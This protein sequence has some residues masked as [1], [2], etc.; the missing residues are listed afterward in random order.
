MDID[1]IIYAVIA[2]LLLG[3]LWVVFGRRNDSDKQRRN[4]FVTWALRADDPTAGQPVREPSPLL[5]AF[6]SAPA[7]MAGGLEQIKSRD[8]RFDEKQFL[9]DA[10]QNFKTIVEDFAKG[11]IAQMTF[12]LMP[13]VLAHFQNALEVRHAA[14][15]TVETRVASITDA[16]TTSVR[17]EGDQAFI[18]VRFISHQENILR[19]SAGQVIAGEAGKIEEVT[20]VWT[21]TRDMV[22]SDS[23]WLVSETGA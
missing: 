11:D 13:A 6:K 4:P 2:V 12:L 7:S 10:R 8:P 14:G 17:M 23:K 15:Q 18:V 9:Q 5:L 20:D 3:R 1:I 16:E 21:F 19:D 22:T